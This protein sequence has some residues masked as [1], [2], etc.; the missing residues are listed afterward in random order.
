MGI[1]LKSNKAVNEGEYVGQSYKMDQ[2]DL[3]SL[4]KAYEKIFPDVYC[5]LENI[6]L[7]IPKQIESRREQLERFKKTRQ[8]TDHLECDGELSPEV[9]TDTTTGDGNKVIKLM[10]CAKCERSLPWNETLR[11]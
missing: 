10:K 9:I 1:P 6:A 7:D 2:S 4:E 5:K 11:D 3:R 8:D